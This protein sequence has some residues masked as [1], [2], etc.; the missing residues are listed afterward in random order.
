MNVI[1]FGN[2]E[3]MVYSRKKISLIAAQFLQC[4]KQHLQEKFNFFGRITDRLDKGFCLRNVAS[5]L[6]VTM[7]TLTNNLFV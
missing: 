7:H 2:Q 4:F 3:K 6:R 1:F 5:D